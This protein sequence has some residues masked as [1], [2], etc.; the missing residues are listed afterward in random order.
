MSGFDFEHC[1]DWQHFTVTTSSRRNVAGYA[2]SATSVHVRRAAPAE[3]RQYRR[4]YEVS[5]LRVLHGGHCLRGEHD[6]GCPGC[7]NREGTD[8]S[9]IDHLGHNQDLWLRISAYRR[10]R[11]RL[12]VWCHQSWIAAR[13]YVTSSDRGDGIHPTFWVLACRI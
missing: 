1:C 6:A 7:L 8:C 5:T 3:L 9:R 2:C 10:R 13:C 11:Q 12:C 4:G